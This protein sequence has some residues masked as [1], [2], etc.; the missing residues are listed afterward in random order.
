MILHRHLDYLTEI[1]I[2][3]RPYIRRSPLTGLLRTAAP[4]DASCVDMSW[5][6][7]QLRKGLED[8]SLT[9]TGI[10]RRPM[11]FKQIA[12]IGSC[13][14]RWTPYELVLDHLLQTQLLASYFLAVTTLP[15]GRTIDKGDCN[16][17]P[18]GYFAFRSSHR[19]LGYWVDVYKVKIIG[20]TGTG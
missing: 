8:S 12:L 16:H 14:D 2:Y 4:G 19:G 15:L 17:S 18:Q 11:H 5:I 1:E 9:M 3:R 13:V 6:E 7:F 20:G 10:Y